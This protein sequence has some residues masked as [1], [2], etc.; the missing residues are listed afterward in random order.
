M[1]AA[2]T[3]WQASQFQ[4]KDQRNAVIQDV[5]V[6][7]AELAKWEARLAHLQED[8]SM[9][10]DFEKA[11]SQRVQEGIDSVVDLSKAKLVGARTRLHLAEARGSVDVLR[12]HL[13]S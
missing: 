6:S 13:A 3:E 4:D 5:S 9:A 12:R 10:A 7:Y 2:K 8:E 11:V 1:K